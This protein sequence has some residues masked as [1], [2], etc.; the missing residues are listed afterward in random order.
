VHSKQLNQ[1]RREL[2]RRAS[3]AS[4]TFHHVLVACALLLG[5]HHQ[6]LAVQTAVVR[7]APAPITAVLTLAD[8]QRLAR[9]SSPE[10]RAAQAA[11]DKA[12][13]LE[14]QAGAFA[15]P[16]FTYGRE[17]TSRAGQSNSQDI[18]QIEQSLEIGG[19]RSARRDAARLR[20]E[21][22]EARLTEATRQLELDVTNAYV[23][24]AAATRQAMLADEMR[25][26]FAEAERVQQQRLNAGE[27]SGYAARRLSL[28]VTRF[29]AQTAE[30]MLAVHKSRVSLATLVAIPIDSLAMHATDTSMI[31]RIGREPLPALDTLHRLAKSTRAD[32]RQRQLE[33]DV[34]TAEAQLIVAERIPSPVFSGGFKRE[35]VD[36]G[37]GAGSLGFS[38]FVAG[39][40]IPLPLFDRRHGAIAAGQADIQR[41]DAELLAL[42][43]RVARDVDVAFESVRT[44]DAQLALLQPHLGER[45]REAVRAV[46]GAY[47]EGEITLVEWLDAMRAFQ[48]AE[49][50]MA[51]VQ[52]EAVIRRAALERAVGLSLFSG[53]SR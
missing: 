29:A 52:A 42:Q 24:L 6:L 3:F 19:Q 39:L 22:A 21:V 13:A 26:T 10:L 5:A 46:Q 23:A 17:Q 34:A 35:S 37:S 48:E 14:R 4:K 43:R 1:R 30:V 50:T 25:R 11:V 15:N 53:N 16:V 45:S 18:A 31:Q 36:N 28:E 8:A 44:V 2:P 12:T 51:M 27:V 38:G 33:V 40:S 49:S 47:A 7:P 41:V 32:L 20:R 9:A